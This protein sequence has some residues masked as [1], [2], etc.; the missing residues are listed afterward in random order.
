MIASFTALNT[1]NPRRNKI[2]SHLF[3]IIPGKNPVKEHKTEFGNEATNKQNRTSANQR[4]E[5]RKQNAFPTNTS[6]I[7][8]HIQIAFIQAAMYLI[9]RQVG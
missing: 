2:C 4:R 9:N 6:I 8:L 5:E 3:S 7:V 1:L